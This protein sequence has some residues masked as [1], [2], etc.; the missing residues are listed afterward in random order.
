MEHNT[1][2]REEDLGNAREA[3]EEFEE[4]MSAEK[5]DKKSQIGWKRKILGGGNYQE[6][7][8]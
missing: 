1:W 8:Q 4:R 7:I 3:V 6:N 5:E 2:E